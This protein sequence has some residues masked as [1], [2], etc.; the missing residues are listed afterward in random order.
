MFDLKVEPIDN[1]KQHFSR[2]YYKNM[3]K[4][5][6]NITAINNVILNPSKKDKSKKSFF[7][8]WKLLN[9]S[10]MNYIDNP[11]DRK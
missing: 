10:A 5:K 9:W 7:E 3:H 8:G 4:N 11:Y 2:R 1:F 6:D